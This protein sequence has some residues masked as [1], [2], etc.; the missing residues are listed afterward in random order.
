MR[1]ESGWQVDPIPASAGIEY[2]ALAANPNFN[3]YFWAA[4]ADGGLDTYH[5]EAVEGWQRNTIV[6]ETHYVDLAVN[7]TSTYY[8]YGARA[9]A[10]L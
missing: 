7:P 6:P 10:G 2:V 5:Y 8:V 3:Y 1:Y 9:D 4:R